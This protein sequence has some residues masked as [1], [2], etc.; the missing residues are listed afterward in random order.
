[1][2]I[3]QLE[4]FAGLT[5]EAPV[6]KEAKQHTDALALEAS[7]YG[8]PRISSTPM[9]SLNPCEGCPMRTLCDDSECGMKL[10]DIFS[11]SDWDKDFEEWLSDPI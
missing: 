4:L 3:I 6:K 7:D 2:R 10:Y 8:R 1:M 11:D 5:W 9:L